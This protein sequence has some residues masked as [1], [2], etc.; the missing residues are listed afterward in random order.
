MQATPFSLYLCM[1]SDQPSYYPP[2]LVYFKSFHR[3]YLVDLFFFSCDIPFTLK[4]A[5]M[6]FIRRESLYFYLSFLPQ[7]TILS[8][9]I[10]N[11]QIKLYLL[12][13]PFEANLSTLM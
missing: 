11:T 6:G 3:S 2:C 10:H 8:Y 5:V 9:F 4:I 7:D 1:H 12:T 13:S